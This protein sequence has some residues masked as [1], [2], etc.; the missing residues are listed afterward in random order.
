[1]I[2]LKIESVNLFDLQKGHVSH[3]TVMPENLH[4]FV[5]LKDLVHYPVLY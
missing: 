1:M 5:V 4:M 3:Y 2:K